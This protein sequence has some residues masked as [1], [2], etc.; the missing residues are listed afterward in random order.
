MIPHAINAQD[1]PVEILCMFDHDGDHA[2]LRPEAAVRPR[3]ADPG[4]TG[5]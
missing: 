5:D 1:G 3:E 2:H 4:G